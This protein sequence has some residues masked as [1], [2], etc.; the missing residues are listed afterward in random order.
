MVPLDGLPEQQR[1][2][3]VIAKPEARTLLRLVAGTDYY[4]VD[5]PT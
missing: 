2:L 3:C 4:N 1:L 5:Y